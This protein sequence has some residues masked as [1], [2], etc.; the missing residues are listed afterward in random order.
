MLLSKSITVL[1][2]TLLSGSHGG[3]GGIGLVQASPVPVTAL[4]EEE[5]IE[6]VSLESDQVLKVSKVSD[7]QF[8]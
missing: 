2:A 5:V 1:T 7:T 3:S 6:G 4:G 8:S